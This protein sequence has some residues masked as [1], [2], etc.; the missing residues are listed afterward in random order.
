MKRRR[1]ACLIEENSFILESYSA[2]A[3]KNEAEASSETT[4][5]YL[6][7]CK[8]FYRKGATKN[9]DHFK[10]SEYSTDLFL[11]R[12]KLLPVVTTVELREFQQH[13]IS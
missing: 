1:L 7:H 13:G 9:S 4:I 6:F 8:L 3:L 2:S 11:A 12:N 5:V 10:V